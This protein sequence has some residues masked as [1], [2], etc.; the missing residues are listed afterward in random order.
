MNPKL[1]LCLLFFLFVFQ[2]GHSQTTKTKAVDSTKVM[3]QKIEKYSNKSNFRKFLH[4]LI[5]SSTQRSKPS[6]NNL[7]DKIGEKIGK[8]EGK[9]IRNIDIVS[10]DPFGYSD[11]DENREP[12]NSFEIFGNKIHIKSKKWTIRNN[13]LFKKNQPLDSLL[14]KESERLLRRQRFVRSV[15]IKTIPIENN[16][17]SIDVSVRV[18]DTWSLIP[19]GAISGSRMNLELTERN[20]FGL[21]QE[22][23]NDFGKQFSD[24]K[25]SYSGKY[26]FN[27]IKNTFIDASFSYSSSFNNDVSKRVIVER[28]FFS[29]ITKYAGGVSYE[30]QKYT[31]SLPTI[32]PEF[33]TIIFENETKSFWLGNASKLF[34]GK[35]IDF[36]STNFVTTIGYK[37]VNYIRNASIMIDPSQF[38][39]GEELYLISFGITTRK[40]IQ[41]KYLFN[42]DIIEDVPFGKVYSITAGFQ[43]KNNTRRNYYGGRFSYGH[44]YPFGYLSTNIELGSFFND[45]K[46]QETTLKIEANYFTSLLSLG[47]WR[48]RQFIKPSLVV[49]IN[50]ENSIKDRISLNS[51]NGFDG[52]T[53]PLFNGTKKLSVVFQTQTYAPGNW[54]GFH[55]S[56]F[57]N[58][59]FG[60]LGDSHDSFL[61][62]K[63][64]SKFTLGVLINNDYLVFNRFQV[65]FSYYPSIPFEDSNVF[66]TNTLKNDDFNI[67]DYTIGQPT[68]V[69]F[70]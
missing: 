51:L 41:D 61:N 64:Y 13:L 17:D 67:P 33:E 52:F 53:N 29:P 69:D 49:G 40:F 24:N 34:K 27:N 1:L 35:S 19:N 6:N 2:N 32:L 42:F 58:T 56:P 62:N 8:S 12:H 66:K 36:R 31:D 26:S 20:F 46:T 50:R 45:T 16:V 65:S 5:F 15:L 25:N 63:L 43:N 70:R 44:Y 48:I 37:K 9:I 38:L 21:G 28:T 60:L 23:E 22:F 11:E 68:I 59:S 55:F 39:S 10:L 54:K 30:T 47:N 18:L 3:Y 57:I 4:K 7:R 14:I